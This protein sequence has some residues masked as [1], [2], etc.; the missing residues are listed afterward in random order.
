MMGAAPIYAN[1]RDHDRDVAIATA[2]ANQSAAEVGN[3]FNLAP[4][5]IRAVCRRLKAERTY[6]IFLVG[7]AGE[8]QPVAVVVTHKGFTAA[9]VAAFREYGEYFRNLGLP[10]W[11]LTDGTSYNTLETIRKIAARTADR[12]VETKGALL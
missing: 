2:R 12:A 6:E 1:A 9:C 8:R 11:W 3:Q 10:G 7:E 5:T 4:G